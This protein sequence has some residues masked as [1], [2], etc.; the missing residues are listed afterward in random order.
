VLKSLFL[1]DPRIERPASV[2]IGHSF[3]AAARVN[4]AVRRFLG[5]GLAK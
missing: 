2:F 5:H 4:E 1:N 3:A